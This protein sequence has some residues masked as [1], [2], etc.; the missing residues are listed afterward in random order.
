[1]LG[2]SPNLFQAIYDFFAQATGRT[3]AAIGIGL[4]FALL[5]F[6]IFF[7]GFSGFKDDVEESQ[8]RSIWGIYY[9]YETGWARIKIMIWILISLGCGVLA[10]YQLPQWFPHV[11]PK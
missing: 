10:Y 6:G 9:D 4:F 3:Y 7:K 1:M 2:N 11:F 5:Y 8:K